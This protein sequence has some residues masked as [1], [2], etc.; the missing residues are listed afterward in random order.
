M[1]ML[2]WSKGGFF[3]VL[4]INIVVVRMVKEGGTRETRVCKAVVLV[5]RELVLWRS[6]YH[7]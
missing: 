6:L 2:N 1:R 4:D 7:Q 5:I 3:L